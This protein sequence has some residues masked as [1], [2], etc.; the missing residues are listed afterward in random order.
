MHCTL[1][2]LKDILITLFI[3][4][5]LWPCKQKIKSF[6]SV[7]L[8][9]KYPVVSKYFFIKLTA[10]TWKVS[11]T[12]ISSTISKKLMTVQTP[13]PTWTDGRQ[14]NRL[15][16]YS[17]CLLQTVVDSVC[18]ML[19][20]HTL[21]LVVWPSRPH[22]MQHL[23]TGQGSCSGGHNSHHFQR[24][25]SSKVVLAFILQIKASRSGYCIGHTPTMRQVL[26][27]SIGDGIHRQLGDVSLVDR[28]LDASLGLEFICGSG[29][30]LWRPGWKW[31]WQM[32]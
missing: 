4:C 14:G 25:M 29:H 16:P 31:R 18:Q 28:H 26:I 5:R 12:K 3:S 21:V 9:Q 20:T 6:N 2:S 27:G 7:K 1:H 19:L 15:C 24:A 32:S 10:R 8:E 17:L 23:L 30:S 22:S 11:Y 13:R